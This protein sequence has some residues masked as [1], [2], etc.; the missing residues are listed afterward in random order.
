MAARSSAGARSATFG[1][2]SRRQRLLRLFDQLKLTR[3]SYLAHWE[4]IAD[5]LA[6]RRGRWYTEDVNRGDRRNQK[7]VDCSP[8]LAARTL[9]SGMMSGITSPARPWFRLTLAGDDE[10][11]AGPVKAW[12][13][14][15]TDRMNSVFLRSNLYNILPIIYGDLGIFGTACMI[16]EEDYD[17]VLR[18]Y[19]VPIGSYVLGLSEVNKVEVFMR[20]FQMSVRQLIQR[21]GMPKDQDRDGDDDQSGQDFDST[22]DRKP[23]RQKIDWSKFSTRVRNHFELGELEVMINVIHAITP[24]EFFDERKL[25]AKFKRFR[26]TYMEMGSEADGPHDLKDDRFLRESGYDYFPVLAPRWETTGEDV[27]ASSCPGMDML[28]DILQLQ[29]GEK[30]IAQAI[31][32]LVR[33]PMVGPPSLKSAAASII[34]GK[35]TY[36][37]ERSGQQGFRPAFQV[38]PRINELEAKQQQIRQR[39]SRGFFED[40]F[41][42]LSE[43]DRRQITAREIDERHEEKLLALGPVLEQ[44]NQDLL[45]P[46]IDVTFNFMIERGMIDDIPE[47]LAGKALRVEFISIMQQAQKLAGLT[48]VERFTSYVGNLAQFDQSVLMKVDTMELVDVY[49]D[50]TSM[51]AGIIRSDEQVQA[52]KDAQAQA[53]AAEQRQQQLAQAAQSA[54]ALSQTDLNGNNALT[55]LM[56]QTN[57]GAIQ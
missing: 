53:Q 33:P 24:N 16:I 56:A 39:I 42:M 36:V 8:V 44:V 11:Q 17:R 57:A 26:S 34:P 7:I 50:I 20:E 51:R 47:E 27:Y 40:L 52:M 21:F 31:E 49:G 37:D 2:E 30:R 9:R 15:T 43:S 48:A 23:L 46:L 45:D 25:D 12:L 5:N 6:P 38:E 13:D 18:G 4:T 29:L 10:I 32:L 54:K 55:S 19:A 14:K 35:I 28:G 3:S 41:L 22:F 1:G